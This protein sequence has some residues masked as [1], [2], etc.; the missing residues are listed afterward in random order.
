MKASRTFLGTSIFRRAID[1]PEI[2][3]RQMKYKTCANGH[4]RQRRIAIACPKARHSA[5]SQLNHAHIQNRKHAKIGA[6]KTF[7]LQ[8]I[9]ELPWYRCARRSA[10]QSSR[11]RSRQACRLRHIAA[12][13][14]KGHLPVRMQPRNRRVKRCAH[15]SQ[16]AV[17]T[18]CAVSSNIV[19]GRL[20]GMQKLAAKIDA[21]PH[22]PQCFEVIVRADNTTKRIH[23]SVRT[24]TRHRGRGLQGQARHIADLCTFVHPINAKLSARRSSYTQKCHAK[25][26]NDL[27]KTHA[28]YST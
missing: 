14:P 23:L 5:I 10:A 2:Q 21:Q 25:E 3:L 12:R 7:I 20:V 16:S 19:G 26:E 28:F 27:T 13:P 11:P 22:R 17:Q 24:R 1:R 6:G 8:K 4:H 15:T 9:V 18:R